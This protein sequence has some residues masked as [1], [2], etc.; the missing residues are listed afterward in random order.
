MLAV[1]AVL[2]L[3][4]VSDAVLLHSPS[5]RRP[6]LLSLPWLSPLSLSRVDIVEASA[7]QPHLPLLQLVDTLLLITIDICRL[8][9]VIEPVATTLTSLITSSFTEALILRKFIALTQPASP[10]ASLL[11]LP[12][13]EEHGLLLS[14]DVVVSFIT[15]FYRHTLYVVAHTHHL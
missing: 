2:V 5:L 8:C 6:P 3:A 11:P 13:Y 10:F 7:S 4:G 1:L 15:L 12:L 14:N 9:V